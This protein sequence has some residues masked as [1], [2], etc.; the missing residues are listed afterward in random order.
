[1]CVAT[2]AEIGSNDVLEED[3][4]G[5][6]GSKAVEQAYNGGGTSDVSSGGSGGKDG[7]NGSAAP[8]SIMQWLVMV[9]LLGAS[10]AM[11]MTMYV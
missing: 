11:L 7:S 5:I 6:A 9:S 3:F 10:V 2:A 4:P 8:A 1:M